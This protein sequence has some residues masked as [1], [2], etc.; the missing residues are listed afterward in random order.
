MKN[1]KQKIFVYAFSVRNAPAEVVSILAN[2]LDN[3][4][5][6]ARAHM[7][8]HGYLEAQL[9]DEMEGQPSVAL[10]QGEGFAHIYSKSASAS[11]TLNA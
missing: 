9:L 8:A 6:A 10:R 1:T 7:A 11:K 2:D 3:A 4:D 5:A